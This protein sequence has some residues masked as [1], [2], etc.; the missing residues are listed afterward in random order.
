MNSR[1]I[2]SRPVHEYMELLKCPRGIKDFVL[3]K[4]LVYAN[5]ALGKSHV[6]NKRT[7]DIRE[8]QDHRSPL[9]RFITAIATG[10]DKW[11]NWI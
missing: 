9:R 1:F 8:R 7:S 5:Q 6:Y 4:P 3:L 2:T 10:L 11:R